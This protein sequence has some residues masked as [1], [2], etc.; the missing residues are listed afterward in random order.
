MLVQEQ[1]PTTDF[2]LEQNTHDKNEV[3]EYTDENEFEGIKILLKTA[4]FDPIESD[5]KIPKEFKSTSFESEKSVTIQNED[6]GEGITEDYFIVQLKGPVKKEWRN[7]IRESGIELYY[8]IPDY[9]FIAYGRLDLIQEIQMLDFVRWVGPFHP[10]YRVQPE[11]M[12]LILSRDANP[13]INNQIIMVSLSPITHMSSL[14]QSVYSMGAIIKVVDAENYLVCDLTVAMAYELIF[15]KNLLWMEFHSY[16]ELFNNKDSR[17]MKI[18]QT[19]NGTFAN[20]GQSLWSYN[21]NTGNFEGFPGTDVVIAMVDSGVDGTHPAFDGKK[22]WFYNYGNNQENTWTDA[23]NAAGH[24]THTSGTSLGTGAWRPQDSG[25]E[26]KYAGMAPAAGLIGQA[27]FQGGTIPSPSKLCVDGVQHG[28]NLSSNSWGWPGT[29]GN[30]DSTAVAYDG[31]VRDSDGKEFT[32][33]FGTGNE[34]PGTIRS[35]STAKNV[36]SV[37]ATDNNDGESVTGFSSGGPTDDDRTKPDVVAPGSMVASCG[38]RDMGRGKPSDGQ[39][40]Y[41]YATGTSM[42]TPG[43]AGAAAVVID[44]INHTYGYVPSPAL[45]KGV[46]INGASPIEG[47]KY[48]GNRQGWGRINLANSLLETSTKRF[49]I[50]DQDMPLET[51]NDLL[52]FFNTSTEGEPL[53]ITLTWTDKPGLAASSKNLVND[54]DLILESPDGKI[55]YG[56]NFQNGKSADG[57]VPDE[58]NNVEG[59]YVPE[60]PKGGWIMTIFARNIPEGPQDFALVVAGDIADVTKGIRDI[61]VLPSLD[62]P[63]KIHLEGDTIVLNGSFQNIGTIPTINVR[64]RIVHID[65]DSFEEYLVDETL[66]L[67]NIQEKRYVEFRWSARRG[68]HKFQLVIDPYNTLREEDET[69]NMVENTIFIDFYGLE[70]TIDETVKSIK[71]GKTT[72]FVIHLYNP[73]SLQDTYDIEFITESVQWFIELNKLETTIQSNRTEAITLSVSPP[74]LALVNESAEVTVKIVSRGNI[75]YRTQ[76]TTRT[77]VE[78]YYEFHLEYTT[79]SKAIKPGVEDFYDITINNTGNGPSDYIIGTIGSKLGWK[80]SPP[81]EKV[82]ITA[83]ETENI[84]L[85]IIPPVDG[86]AGETFEVDIIVMDELMEPEQLTIVTIID[87]VFLFDLKV[88]QA[89]YSVDIGDS[90]HYTLTLNNIGNIVDTYRLSYIIPSNWTASLTDTPIELQPEE[91]NFVK[92]LVTIPKRELPDVYKLQISMESVTINTVQNYT[93]TLE[94]NQFYDFTVKTKAVEDKVYQ[95]QVA[96]YELEVFN[97][98]T[99]EDL[100]KIEEISIPSNWRLIFDNNVLKIDYEGD[101]KTTI[102]LKTDILAEDGTYTTELKITSAGNISKYIQ[103]SIETEIDHNLQDK[104][105]FETVE[106]DTG[107]EKGLFGRGTLFDLIIFVIIIVIVIVIIIVAFT[108]SKKKTERM[109]KI[110]AEQAKQRQAVVDFHTTYKNLYNEDI[111]SSIQPPKPYDFLEEPSR[112]LAPQLPVR[113]PPG[114][115][116]DDVYGAPKPHPSPMPVPLERQMPLGPL[117]QKGGARPKPTPEEPPQLPP[118]TDASERRPII[119]NGRLRGD[120]LE[121]EEPPKSEPRDFRS[122]RKIDLF[123]PQKEETEAD[124]PEYETIKPD[125]SIKTD[126]EKKGPQYLESTPMEWKSVDKE[127]EQG[128]EFSSKPKVIEA[129]RRQKRK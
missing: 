67:V 21:H 115:P 14:I 42:A 124:E 39:N 35:P 48:P 86:M 58:L 36:I 52:Y 41:F 5:P 47:Y 6:S 81:V 120:D 110:E 128:F 8:Y 126:F 32:I 119:R 31:L 9:A 20:D 24:G 74:S 50:I 123:I 25:E 105:P 104:G 15:T 66:P 118:V 45:V 4:E 80:V 106:I 125:R 111:K 109:N 22:I 12:D 112:G 30:Y 87:K 75:T 116:R 90:V 51:D 37:G 17:I 64:Y 96:E 113:G 99:G 1:N 83:R 29:A 2:H 91:N 63:D 56:N 38:W 34:G 18:R 95:G 98:G 23:G 19:N 89:I 77:I 108:R 82:T 121:A 60:A 26:A 127:Y 11:L 57:V 72:Q 101:N 27:I 70:T 43:G 79:L 7:S 61:K 103:V 102:K 69:N 88:P 84:T 85:K 28:A 13:E 16:P 117:P 65:P 71:P 54:I 97:N 122:K 114:G 3:N 73:G 10:Y 53:R 40:S 92:F 100:I 62:F 94:V 46:M 78:Q 59:L 129:K 93:I 76:I 49:F 107:D 33:V 68:E 55:Y 44:Y